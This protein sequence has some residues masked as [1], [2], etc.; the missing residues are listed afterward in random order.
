MQNISYPV[1]FK[2][3]VSTFAN[4]FIAKD[5]NEQ[6]IAYVRQKMFK[7]KEDI[8]I[9]DDESR[10]KVNYSIKADRWLDFSAAYSFKDSNGNEFGKIVRKGWRSIWKARYEIINKEEQHQ[11]SINEENGWIKVLDSMMGE[12]PVVGIFTG[13]MFNPSYIVTDKAGQPIV[14]LKKKASFFGRKFEL[15]KVGEVKPED[16]EKIML[17]LMMMIL[18][19]RRRG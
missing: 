10:S 4:D 5:A 9:F 7:L 8:Q 14:R 2:F 1:N 16:S 18:L 13:Y 12:V 11:F 3:K 19:E 17:G 15:T 6:T